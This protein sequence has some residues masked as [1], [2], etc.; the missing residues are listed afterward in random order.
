MNFFL[1]LAFLFLIGSIV[2]WCIEVIFRKFFSKS[3]PN[4]SWINPGFLIGP[5][6][7]LYGFGVCILFTLSI[8]DNCQLFKYYLRNKAFLFLTMGIIMTV[9]EYIAGLIFIKGLKVKLWD[10]SSKKGNIQ[11]IVCP[12]FTLLWIAA[13][14]VYYYFV[15]PRILNALRWLSKNLA[16]SFFIGLFFGFF[17]V[18]LVY[19]S[20]ILSKIKDFADEHDIIVKYEELKESI[21]ESKE[22]GYEKAKFLFAMRSRVS[23]IDH[24]NKYYESK[25]EVTEKIKDHL[26]N[27]K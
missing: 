24:L 15:H 16:F 19:S 14:I 10:Y 3:N 22:K 20:H 6:L 5:Y 4:H 21:R 12:Q 27:K 13:G 26:L 11:G 23:I 9:I 7:P 25:K 18:D 17:I 2:G 1:I 8:L